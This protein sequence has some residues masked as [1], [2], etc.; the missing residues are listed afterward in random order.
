MRS[1]HVP[2][3]ADLVLGLAVSAQLWF[4]LWSQQHRTSRECDFSFLDLAAVMLP[5]CDWLAIGQLISDL[6]ILAYPLSWL[7]GCC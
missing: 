7:L 4:A 5:S 6:Y 3:L 2:T 1:I